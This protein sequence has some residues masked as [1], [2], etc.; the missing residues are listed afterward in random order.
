MVD[1]LAA[2][3]ALCHDCLSEANPFA[4]IRNHG[5][6][7]RRNGVNPTFGAPAADYIS[8]TGHRRLGEREN[9][10]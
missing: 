3:E 8:S 5:A 4:G 7:A 6:A 10:R 1:P 9:Y 2:S